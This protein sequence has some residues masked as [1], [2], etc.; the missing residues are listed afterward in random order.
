MTRFPQLTASPQ[1]HFH[2]TPPS[3]TA[4][5]Q[6][7]AQARD[8]AN[9]KLGPHPPVHGGKVCSFT[10]FPAAAADQP[11]PAT[12]LFCSVWRRMFHV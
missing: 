10:A 4:K 6:R 9:Q 2:E 11:F 8:T 1:T 7:P 12:K 3:H 5:A